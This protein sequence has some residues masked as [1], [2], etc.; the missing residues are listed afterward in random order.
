MEVFDD[1]FIPAGLRD[2]WAGARH[3]PRCVWPYLQPVASL[4]QAR[5]LCTSCGHCW[6]IEHGALRPVDPVVCHGCAE[7]S[8]RDCIALLQSEFPRFGVGS[9]T[10][11]ATA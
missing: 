2:V 5:W 6:R 4:D 1:T 8:K 7:R 10:A 9:E 3:C 11:G